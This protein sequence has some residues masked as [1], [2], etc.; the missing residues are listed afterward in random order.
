[1]K[2]MFDNNAVDIAKRQY[3]QPHEAAMEGDAG[4]LAMF[5]RVA[6]WVAGAELSTERTEWSKR[7]YELMEEKRFCPGGRILAGANTNH[8]NGLN[9]FVQDASPYDGSTTKGVLHLAT[10]LALVTKV[11]G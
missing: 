8:N 4:I 10:K 5:R 3:L 2:L 7:F 6:D 11:G 9:C 1:M